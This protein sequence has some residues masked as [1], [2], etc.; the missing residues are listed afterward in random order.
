M[1]LFDGDFFDRFDIGFVMKVVNEEGFFHVPFLSEVQVSDFCRRLV[2]GNQYL[3][4][5]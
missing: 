1:K 2:L 3:P 5:D 4:S